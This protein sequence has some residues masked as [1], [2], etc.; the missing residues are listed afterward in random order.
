METDS[1]DSE[2]KVSRGHPDFMTDVKLD[3]SPSV[4]CVVFSNNCDSC[5]TREGFAKVFAHFFH[6][7]LI[8]AEEDK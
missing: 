8:R 1:N 7:R 4:C 2:M 6:G 5:R 3:K